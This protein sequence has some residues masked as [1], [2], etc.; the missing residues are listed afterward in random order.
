M[1]WK[2]PRK[3][4]EKQ[5]I[6]KVIRFL[7]SELEAQT[8]LS[9]IIMGYAD[10]SALGI[11]H[12]DLKPANIFIKTNQMKIA[13]FGFAMLAEDSNAELNSEFNV[14]S[15]YYMA[16]EA[17]KDNKYSAKSD[18]WAIGVIAYELVFGSQPWRSPI[19]K[20]LYEAIQK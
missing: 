10:L 3:K 6:F 1:R 16:P 4:A 13:D 17:L 7:S 11:I 15:S 2:R 14:G 20:V 19:D 8:V 18:I 9:Q 12:R 5:K